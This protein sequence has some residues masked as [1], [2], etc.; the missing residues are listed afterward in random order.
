M[1]VTRWDKFTI[2]LHCL[3]FTLS[4][5][6]YDQVNLES[7]APRGFTRRAPNLEGEVIRGCIEEFRKIAED[8][9]EEKGGYEINLLKS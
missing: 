7:P 9:D 2:P 5:R 3:G 1:L 6:F 4:L 8:V